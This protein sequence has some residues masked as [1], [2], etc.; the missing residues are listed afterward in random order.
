MTKHARF[1]AS[2]ISASVLAVLSGANAQTTASTAASENEK[3]HRLCRE[4]DFQTVIIY[5]VDGAA[6]APGTHSHVA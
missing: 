5:P 4:N 3:L 2:S 6:K 1:V